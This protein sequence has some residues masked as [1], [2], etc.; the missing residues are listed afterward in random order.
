MHFGPHGTVYL[1]AAPASYLCMF[2]I[3]ASL[4]WVPAY[5]SVSLRQP[6]LCEGLSSSGITGM[7]LESNGNY[8]VFD[9]VPFSSSFGK[10]SIIIDFDVSFK[11][12]AGL[13]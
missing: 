11:F 2:N 1:L 12:S 9:N 3:A 7:L 13:L 8:Y 10:D 5:S 6:S 4:S